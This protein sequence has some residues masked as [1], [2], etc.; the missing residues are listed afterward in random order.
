MVTLVKLFLVLPSLV[1]SFPKPPQR[2]LILEELKAGNINASDLKRECYGVVNK[3]SGTNDTVCVSTIAA[4][5]Q[6]IG[7]PWVWG[8]RSTQY[9]GY[10]E[11]DVATNT[12]YYFWLVMSENDPASAPL[13]LWLNGGPGVSSLLGLFDQWGPMK[14]KR[15]ENENPSIR[16]EAN[17]YRMTEKMS[18]IFLE[19]PV[20]TGFSTSRRAATTS[21]DAAEGVLQF[22]TGFFAHP[23]THNGVMVDFTTV[24]F[25]IAG[26]SYAGHYISAIG[27]DLVRR[28]WPAT[29]R[30]LIIGNGIID[31]G[32]LPA[33]TQEVSYKFQTLDI[34][35]SR[36]VRKQH[37]KS[38]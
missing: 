12:K 20:G 25:H 22:L 4:P 8:D 29:L 14:I 10:I 6:G 38:I 30:S 27:D 34:L 23:F 18:W 7:F 15:F 16:L 31:E 11:H 5:Q 35:S 19:Q 13:V 2:P 33:A 37:T 32:L 9:C 17:P 24:P 1:A 36:S 28:R 26:E 3:E 21:L